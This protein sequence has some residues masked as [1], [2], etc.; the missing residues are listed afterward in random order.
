[1]SHVKDLPKAH[2][3]SPLDS[4][5]SSSSGR[6]TRSRFRVSLSAYGLSVGP[7]DRRIAMRRV[8]ISVILAA[9]AIGLSVA[10]AG[11]SNWPGN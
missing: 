4:L 6:L 11:A 7:E 2:T 3:R 5:R 1:M 8:L 10:S 9:I